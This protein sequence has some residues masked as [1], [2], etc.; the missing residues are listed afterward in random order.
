MSL[1]PSSLTG[2]RP[3]LPD[4]DGSHIEHSS[5]IEAQ[6]APQEVDERVDTF[7][8]ERYRVMAIES[9]PAPEGCAGRDWFVYRIT[10]GDNAITGYRRGTRETVSTDVDTIVASLNGRREWS[11]GKPL[12]KARGRGAVAR[13]KSAE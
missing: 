1:P 10:Q 9:A 4:T 7:H 12:S 11:K 2:E 5:V 6:P 8:E 13:R 3:E